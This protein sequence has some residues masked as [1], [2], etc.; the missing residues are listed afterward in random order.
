MTHNKNTPPVDPT[1]LPDPEDITEA[2]LGQAPPRPESTKKRRFGGTHRQI[3]SAMGLYKFTSWLTGIFL[4]LLVLQMIVKYGFQ[5]ELFAGGVTEDGNEFVLGL[6]HEQAVVEGINISLLVLIVHGWLYV[7]YLL[8]CFRLWSMMRW[9]GV[10]LL[11]MA[12]GGVVP[13]LSFFVEKKVNHQAE[14]ELAAHPEGVL[15]Y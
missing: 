11:A 2:D 10:R 6:F 4:L 13:F 7:L 5:R 8:A 3:R 14:A 1:T 9:G 15:R 12:G